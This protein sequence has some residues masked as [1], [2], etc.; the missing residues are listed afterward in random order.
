MNFP[1]EIAKMV[2]ATAS[3]VKWLFIDNR[4]F[5]IGSE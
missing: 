5:Q 2:V 3:V 1:D 4:L